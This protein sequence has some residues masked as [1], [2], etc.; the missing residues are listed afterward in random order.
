M[1]EYA[2]LLIFPVRVCTW[3]AMSRHIRPVSIDA[4]L[5]AAAWRELQTLVGIVLIVALGYALWR[6][7][8]RSAIF[9]LLLL[10]WSAYLPVSGLITLNATVAEH[11]LYLPSAFLVSRGDDRLSIRQAGIRCAAISQV[12]A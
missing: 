6:T 12:F 9:L 2:G 4:S 1:A 11:W 3:S 8:K 5:D 10:L 7:R